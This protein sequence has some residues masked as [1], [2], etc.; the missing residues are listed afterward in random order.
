[1]RLVKNKALTASRADA[2]L[3]DFHVS[4][5]LL[6]K[7]PGQFFLLLL[8]SICEALSLMSIIYFVYRGLGLNAHPYSDLLTMQAMLHI[9]ASFT[10]LPGASGAQ[11]GGFYLFFESFFPKSIIFAAMF[12]WR[13]IT[14]YLSIICGFIAVLID[15][16]K[17]T[18]KKIKEQTT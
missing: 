18:P 6:T 10:P 12:V 5:N 11:E 4:V 3:E 2:A 16:T 7:S 15:N 14:Y 1:M 8:L 13:F 9:A 17:K